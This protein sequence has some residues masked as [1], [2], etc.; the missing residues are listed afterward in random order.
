VPIPRTNFDELKNQWG[1]SGY[2][3]HDVKRCEIMARIIALIYNWWTLF[4]RLA[5]PDKHVEA[6]SSRPLL[7]HAIAR[8]TRHSNRTK[9]SIT[10]TH[11]KA[12]LVQVVLDEISRVLSWI[13]STTEQLTQ[14]ERWRQILSYAFRKFLNRAPLGGTRKL[15]AATP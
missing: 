13:R 3:T 6:I 14:N 4:A 1:W 8:Q 7:L 9:V 2:T 5:N 11:A 12:E 15:A 10:S